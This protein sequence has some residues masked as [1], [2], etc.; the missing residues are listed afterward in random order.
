[1]FLVDPN[2]RGAGFGNQLIQ[3]AIHFAD[4]QII[5]LSYSGLTMILKLRDTFMKIMDLD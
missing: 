2:L 3:K 4:R 5:R 1:M